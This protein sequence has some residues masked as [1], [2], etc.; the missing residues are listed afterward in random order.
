M[1]VYVADTQLI[2]FCLKFT[3]FKTVSVFASKN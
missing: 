3:E 2:L 1:N